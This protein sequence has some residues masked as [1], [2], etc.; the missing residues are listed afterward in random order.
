MLSTTALRRSPETTI[1]EAIERMLAD[2]RKRYF[3]VDT[4]RRLLGAVDR[5][6]LLL[7]A[8]GI[9]PQASIEGVAS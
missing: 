9:E 6:D 3:V 8:A 7:A 4:E 2:G 1:G 5:Q